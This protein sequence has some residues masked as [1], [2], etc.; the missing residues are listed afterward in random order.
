MTADFE[1][2]YDIISAASWILGHARN[3]GIPALLV[4]IRSKK[5]FDCLAEQ[6]EREQMELSAMSVPIEELFLH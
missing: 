4:T 2:R 3:T 5:T 6:P 1:E